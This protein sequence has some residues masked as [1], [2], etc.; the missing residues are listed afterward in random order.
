[1]KMKIEMIESNSSN[2]NE[3]T[4]GV[5]AL[6]CWSVCVCVCVCEYTRVYGGEAEAPDGPSVAGSQH[7]QTSAGVTQHNP[8]TA[9]AVQRGHT[10]QIPE[11]LTRAHHQRQQELHLLRDTDTHT[12]RERE[13]DTH[14]FVAVKRYHINHKCSM[15][16]LKAQ[17]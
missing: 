13:S 6:L 11:T 3:N 14:Q 12:H 10:V 2:L 5:V 1:M 16:Y 8:V 9:T 17:Y 15:E 7:R 4:A